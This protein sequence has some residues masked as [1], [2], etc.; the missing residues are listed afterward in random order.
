MDAVKPPYALKHVMCA[1]GHLST[2]IYDYKL[3]KQK[4]I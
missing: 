2:M 3:I 4:F 1:E